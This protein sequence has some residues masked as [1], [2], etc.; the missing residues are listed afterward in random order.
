MAS[1]ELE[2]ILNPD[3]SNGREPVP[4]KDRSFWAKKWGKSSRP[5]TD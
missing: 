5:K 1:Q 2:L 3:L 4:I